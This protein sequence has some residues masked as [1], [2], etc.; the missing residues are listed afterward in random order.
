M[1]RNLAVIVIIVILVGIVAAAPSHGSSQGSTA[2]TTTSELTSGSVVTLGQPFIV[3]GTDDVPVQVKFTT[4]WFSMGGGY[5]YD[6]A[7]PPNKLFVLQFEMTNVGMR[8]T[9]VFSGLSKW[10]VVVDKGYIY[11][12]QF[13]LNFSD[14]VD[15]AQTVTNDVVFAILATTTPTQVTYYDTCAGSTA[16]CSPTYMVDLSGKTIPVKEELQFAEKSLFSC[17]LQQ[18][19]ANLVNVTNTGLGPVTIADVYYADQIVSSA[20]AQVQPGQTVGIPITIPTSV[21]PGFAQQ[22]DLKVVTTSGNAFTTSC[23]YEGS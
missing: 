5:G 6:G 14:K 18:G 19:V 17:S 20:P 16:D 23:Y 1:K 4:A 12:S 21:Q 7:V 15:P 8:T 9:T 22:H 2:E 3:K 13:N 10:D 11:D